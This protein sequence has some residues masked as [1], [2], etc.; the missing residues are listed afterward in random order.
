MRRGLKNGL[1]LKPLSAEAATF[2][3]IGR[4]TALRLAMF[5][6]EKIN[7]AIFSILVV[8][9]LL[10]VAALWTHF[11]LYY[12]P[13]MC[14]NLSLDRARHDALSASLSDPSRF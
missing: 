6:N 4:Q 3:P 10:G 12:L 7:I 11:Q 13:V 8:L 9:Q 14:R 1:P 5:K 2:S